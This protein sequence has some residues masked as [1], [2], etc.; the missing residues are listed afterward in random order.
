MLVAL[1]VFLVV[2][3]LALGSVWIGWLFFA[4]GLLLVGI[5]GK[6]ASRRS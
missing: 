4:S 6:R 1:L 5:G 3:K 2:N